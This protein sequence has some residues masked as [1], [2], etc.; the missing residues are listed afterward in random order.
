MKYLLIILI[1]AQSLTALERSKKPPFKGHETFDDTST[2]RFSSFS[3]KNSTFRNGVLWTK[4]ES[5]RKYPPTVRIPIEVT[6]CTISF[7]YR[8]LGE[9]GHIQFFVNGYR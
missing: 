3:V 4:G 9:G 8:F 1:L 6:D 2:E 7:R 5:G